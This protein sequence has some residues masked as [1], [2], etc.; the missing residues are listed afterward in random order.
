MKQFTNLLLKFSVVIVVVIALYIVADPFKVVWHYNSYFENGKSG[1]HVNRSIAGAANFNNKY[2]EYK[3]NSYIFGNSRSLACQ[4]SEWQKH[5]PKAISAYHF[6]GAGE[7]LYALNKKLALINRTRTPIKH[8]LF[9][10]D[11]QLLR[12]STPNK[13]HLFTVSPL[14]DP[15]CNTL[16]YHAT[17]LKAFLSYKFIFY[18]VEFKLSGKLKPYMV[19]TFYR[20]IRY[21]AVTNEMSSDIVENE[22]ANGTYYTSERISNFYK[23]DTIQTFFKSCLKGSQ[24][25]LL[26]EIA[27]ILKC[28]NTN[29]KIIINP[30]YDQKKLST[31]DMHYLKTLFGDKNIFDFSGINSFTNN[32][33]NYYET[34]HYRPHVANAILDSIY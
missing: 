29:Y 4:V 1:I 23:R 25:E 5:L 12:Q 30:C 11:Q 7:S 6:D 32:Y 18:Y 14:I 13:G 20:P 16:S 33:Q 8:A 2:R 24:K 22:L 19:P 26:S 15:K 34:V 27:S 21:N 31:E 10:V 28:N 9:F 17:F 3:Y